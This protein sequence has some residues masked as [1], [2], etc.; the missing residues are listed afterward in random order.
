M[1]CESHGSKCSGKECT[2]DGSSANASANTNV[3][4]GL[5]TRLWGPSGWLFLHCIT[6]GYPY[7]IDPTNPEHLAKQN[8][9]YR[10]FYYLGKVLPCKYCRNSYDEFFES[11]SPMRH[12]GSRE[13][14]SKWL[15]D[16]HNLINDKLG[17]P[18]CERPTYDEIKT[19]YESFRAACKPLTEK[20]RND[21]AGKG[22][23]APASGKP[24]RC[25]IKVVEYD[26]IAPKPTALQEYPKS[27]DYIVISKK[28]AIVLVLVIVI[29]LAG[30]WYLLSG[31]R[32][33]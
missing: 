20:E 7:K 23:I 6:F 26:Q 27:D 1:P 33:L 12:L 2:N 28:M 16:I 25:V 3:D 21:K 17:V 8:D 29:I 5:M 18:G 9:Y 14:L 19:R 32:K 10:F 24:K 11:N 4:N 30:G 15:F 31:K 22:C 13:E